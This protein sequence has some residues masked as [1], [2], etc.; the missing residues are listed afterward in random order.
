MQLE[1]FF[2]SKIFAV[3]GYGLIILASACLVFWLGVTV[4]MNKAD[5]S[6]KWGE[7]YQNNFGGMA[8]RRMPLPDNN[9]FMGAHG[10]LGRIIKIDDPVLVVEDRGN[11]EI[12]VIVDSRTSIVKARDNIKLSD[13]NVDD[14]I[15]VIGEPDNQGR[16]SARLIRVFPAGLQNNN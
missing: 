6:C 15:V 5:F 11:T 10:V 3:I 4:G 12:N 8:D 9:D 14:S 13:L 2:K 16:I 7:N 1:N